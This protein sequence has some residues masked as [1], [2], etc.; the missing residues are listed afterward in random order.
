MALKITD[1]CNNCTACEPE[2]PSDAIS[3]GGDIFVINPDLC[4]ECVG[5]FGTPQCADVCPVECCVDDPDRKEDEVSL[6]EKA[7]K[8]SPEKDFS[9]VFPSRYKK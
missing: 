7:K 2:C 3:E 1:D 8:I 9:G 5:Y 4:T 6:I